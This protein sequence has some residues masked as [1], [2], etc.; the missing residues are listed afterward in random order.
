MRGDDDKASLLLQEREMGT[1]M[2]GNSE[3]FNA[4]AKYATFGI[5]DRLP[6]NIG[7]AIGARP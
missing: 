6:V 4:L 2:S 1:S 5:A 3:V 7:M